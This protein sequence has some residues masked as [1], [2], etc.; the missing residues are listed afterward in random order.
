[1][2]FRDR[3]RDRTSL[4]IDQRIARCGSVERRDCLRR[5]QASMASASAEQPDCFTTYPAPGG[6]AACTRKTKE[7]ARHSVGAAILFR[8]GSWEHAEVLAQKTL[9]HR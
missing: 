4:K 3:R 5:V 8:R 9:I 1:M 7:R 2:T 6:S